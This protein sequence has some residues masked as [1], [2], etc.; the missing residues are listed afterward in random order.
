MMF[1]FHTLLNHCIISKEI[2]VVDVQ[3]NYS[4][5]KTF[6]SGLLQNGRQYAY[7]VL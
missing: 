2:F 1:V 5:S 6:M 4:F 3:E 7:F